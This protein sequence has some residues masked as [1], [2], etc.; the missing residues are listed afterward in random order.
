MQVLIWY[1]LIKFYICDAGA[2]QPSSILNSWQLCSN[3][4]WC[5]IVLKKRRG[6]GPKLDKFKISSGDKFRR[7]CIEGKSVW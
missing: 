1:L 3:L 4:G 2:G 6:A 7:H 5:E